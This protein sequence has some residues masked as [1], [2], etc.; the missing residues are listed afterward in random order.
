M[1][2]GAKDNEIADRFRSAKAARM[3]GRALTG[4]VGA[5][6]RHFL[7]SLEWQDLR[8]LVVAWYGSVCM[9][10]GHKSASPNVDHIRPRKT[11]PYL[12]LEFSNLQVLCGRCNK[13]KGNKPAADYRGE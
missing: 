7:A 10:C 13:A 5:T 2:Y 9:K 1:K 8:N 6:S 12:A 4:P 3:L 11:H